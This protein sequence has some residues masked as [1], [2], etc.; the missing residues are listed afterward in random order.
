[1]EEVTEVCTGTIVTTNTQ[2][3]YTIATSSFG[4]NLVTSQN[5]QPISWWENI[6]FFRL[7]KGLPQ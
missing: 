7:D 4:T 2:A 5:N 6:I 1:M 3:T